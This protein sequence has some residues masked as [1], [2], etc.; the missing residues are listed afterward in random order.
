MTKGSIMRTRRLQCGLGGQQVKL[1]G[2]PGQFWGQILHPEDLPAQ[3]VKTQRPLHKHHCYAPS[4]HV[5]GPGGSGRGRRGPGVGEQLG[6]SGPRN[7]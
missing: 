6:E 1:R 4:S 2:I 3:G 5:T 7:S